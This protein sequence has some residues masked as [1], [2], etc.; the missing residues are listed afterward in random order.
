MAHDSDGEPGQVLNRCYVPADYNI[1]YGDAA[2][3]FDRVAESYG[4]APSDTPGNTPAETK[5]GANA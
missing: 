5:E 4:L 1:A 3:Y 2:P